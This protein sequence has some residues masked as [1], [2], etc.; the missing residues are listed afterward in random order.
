MNKWMNEWIIKEL[1]EWINNQTNK[2]PWQTNKQTTLTNQQIKGIHQL[3]LKQSITKTTLPISSAAMAESSPILHISDSCSILNKLNDIL[4]LYIF[5]FPGRLGK[6]VIFYK[7]KTVKGK[8]RNTGG[9][10]II[11]EKEGGHDW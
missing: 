3:I 11:L 10:S 5:L 6:N 1:Y 8:F 2:Q 9:E 7:K 4:G